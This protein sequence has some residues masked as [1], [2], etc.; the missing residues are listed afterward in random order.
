[1]TLRAVIAKPNQENARQQDRKEMISCGSFLVPDKKQPDYRGLMCE[2]ATIRVYMG[3]SASS[4]VVHACVWFRGPHGSEIYASGKGSAGGGGYH[5]ESA[6]IADA[7]R[8]AGIVLY[9]RP[10]SARL[11]P[12]HDPKRSFDFGGTGSSY[13]REVFEAIARA[14]GH[15]FT[16][17][18]SAWVTH[19][20]L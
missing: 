9:G 19:G 16:S 6:A 13:Y 4:S 3:K 5:K 1:M 7:V 17:R 10:E 20:G 11:D 18:N 12:S 8:S 15:R 2:A 14:M